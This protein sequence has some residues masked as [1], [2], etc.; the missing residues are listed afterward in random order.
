[1][2]KSAIVLAC[3]DKFV[4][5]TSCVAHQIVRLS[6]GSPTIFVLSD[7]VSE[8]N[9]RLARD[10]CKN[11]EFIEIS[12]L[13]PPQK[14]AA[15]L[16]FSRANYARLLLD[17]IFDFERVLYIDSDVLVFNDIEPLLGFPLRAAPIAA[18]YDLAMLSQVTDFPNFNSGVAL[19]DLNAVRSEGLFKAAI[20][21]ALDNPEKCA[22]VDQDALNHVLRGRWQVL[23]WRWNLHGFCAPYTREQPF[24]RHFTGPHKPWGPIKAGIERHYTAAWR[25]DLRSSPWPDKFAEQSWREELRLRGIIGPVEDRLRLMFGQRSPGRKGHKAR[26]MRRFESIQK[27]IEAQSAMGVA[28]KDARFNAA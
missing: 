24:I 9:K 20:Q 6:S 5:Y 2:K 3:D 16:H 17:E 8:Y 19:F 1:M 22:L 10:F 4:A 11:I 13:F 18:G 12:S 7:S 21:F 23:D 14:L 27:N 15:G 25:E 26:V 28:A